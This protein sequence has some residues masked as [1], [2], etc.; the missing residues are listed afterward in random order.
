MP[1]FRSETRIHLVLKKALPYW[2]PARLADNLVRKAREFTGGRTLG[3][4]A[5]SK[6]L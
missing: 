3:Q 1:L 2:V 5:F 6:P 4:I